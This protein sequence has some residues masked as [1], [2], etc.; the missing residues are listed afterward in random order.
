MRLFSDQ[1]AIL[2]SSYSDTGAGAT[3]LAKAAIAASYRDL[4]TL[5]AWSYLQRRTQINTVASYSTGTITYTAST[6]TLTL[7]SG[8]FPT[9]SLYGNVI[10]DGNVYRVQQRVSSTSI[11]LTADRSPVDDFAA[12]T[13]YVIYRSEYPLPADYVRM[14]R[15]VQIGELWRMSYVAPMS[16][17]D[18]TPTLFNPN[19]PWQFT[20]HGSTQLGN[21]MAIE[22]LPPPSAARTYDMAYQAKPR[23]RTLLE[24]YPTGPITISGT[25]VTGVGTTFTSAMVGCR[26]RVGTTTNVPT[27]DY[28]ASPSLTE[29]T[30]L[31]FTST[32]SLTLSETATTVA[33]AVK[34][35]I[36]DPIDI[37]D[38]AMVTLFERMC[39]AE[40]E[41]RCRFDSQARTASANRMKQALLDARAADS[42]I[43]ND[44]NST[45]PA[46]P[47]DVLMLEALNP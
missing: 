45:M 42:R 6:R 44:F 27:H 4:P 9:W 19:R 17:L 32:T 30:I 8:T 24:A 31:A 47:G 21:R 13:A 33:S 43:T 25:T 23:P 22:F 28:G 7:A 1:L 41:Q 10:L 2:L 39:E 40:F 36:D 5:Y 16:M 11:I 38:S 29:Y 35:L 34:Y 15:L 46:G 18:N 12:G 14:F 20:L 3:G 26:L 37:E